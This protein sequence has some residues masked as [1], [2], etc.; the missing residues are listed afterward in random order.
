MEYRSNNQYDF[1]VFPGN[2][3]GTFCTRRDF[4][5]SYGYYDHFFKVVELNGDALAG[6][7]AMCSAFWAA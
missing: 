5:L 6:L 3:Y 1:W 7:P 4:D 2:G